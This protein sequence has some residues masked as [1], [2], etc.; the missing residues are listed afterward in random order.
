MSILVNVHVQST[1]MFSKTVSYNNQYMQG[2]N[3]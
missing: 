3:N 2:D 1:F